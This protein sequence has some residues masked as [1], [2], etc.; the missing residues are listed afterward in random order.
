MLENTAEAFLMLKNI[1][2]VRSSYPH[3][4]TPWDV[5]P[6]PRSPSLSGVRACYV[7][8][9]HKEDPPQGLFQLLLA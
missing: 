6:P 4:P 8:D 7:K 9:L 3:H 5:E 2:T 1:N